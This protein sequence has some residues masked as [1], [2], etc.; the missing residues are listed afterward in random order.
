MKSLQESDS[1]SMYPNAAS[2]FVDID[3]Y[4][5]ITNKLK[6]LKIVKK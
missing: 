4:N 6:Y 3:E 2:A 1:N 5:N